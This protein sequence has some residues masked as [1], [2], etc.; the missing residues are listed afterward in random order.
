[1]AGLAG[2][3]ASWHRHWWCE[4]GEG[5]GKTPHTAGDPAAAPPGHGV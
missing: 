3:G 2:E 1:M 4:G 5:A